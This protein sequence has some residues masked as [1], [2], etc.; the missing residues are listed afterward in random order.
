MVSGQVYH[1]IILELQAD[2]EDQH[3]LLTRLRSIRNIKPNVTPSPNAFDE[4]FYGH[5]SAVEHL[6]NRVVTIIA[7][8][9]SIASIAQV[10]HY[11]L[12]K[13]R[14]KTKEETIK[15]FAYTTSRPRDTSIPDGTIRIIHGKDRF[16]IG[17]NT[18]PKQIIAALSRFSEIG[19]YRSAN[20]PLRKRLLE[21]QLK[22]T[23]QQLEYAEETVSSCKESVA[24]FGKPPRLKYTWQKDKL[25]RYKGKLRRYQ[26]KTNSLRSKIAK[27]DAKIKRLD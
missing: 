5:A 23:M 9:G 15:G 7:T 26:A 14:R 6:I 25:K 24:T 17:R 3:T 18:P 1:G 13:R 20:M 12:A 27:L 11:F 4:W 10:L 16:E 22:K 21:I 8:A 19:N 2:E